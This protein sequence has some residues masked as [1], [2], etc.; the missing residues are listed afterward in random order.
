MK[1]VVGNWKMK[2][3]TRESVALARGVIMALR[4]KKILPE[5]IICPPFVAFSEVRKVV[6][7]S[8]VQMGAQDV[9]WEEEGSFTGEISPRMMS[10]LGVTHALIGHSERRSLLNETD[11][12]VNKKIREAKDEGLIPILCVGENQ[13][14]R[15]AGKDFDIVAA[16]LHQGLTGIRFRPKDQL[17]VA[18]E[19]IW[20]IGTGEAAHPA[21]AVEMH[22][23]IRKHLKEI[24]KN[25][26]SV[27]ILYGGSV[28]G[29]NVYSFLR[30]PEVDG[31]LVGGA[32]VKLAQFGQIINSA[33]EAMEGEK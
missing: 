22:S 6:A 23:F 1:T 21:D 24:L 8:R 17:Y 31:V 19:P 27:K 26:P 20:A 11:E 3:G 9:F 25:N 18:Y 29:E 2:V 16:Q 33:I 4:G 5:V 7:R 28:D 12:M 14:Q 10:E 13:E 32:S 30:E 15:A